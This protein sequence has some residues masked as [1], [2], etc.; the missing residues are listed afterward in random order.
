MSDARTLL[1]LQNLDID[2]DSCDA[3]LVDIAASLGESPDLIAAREA[4]TAARKALDDLR[5]T[6]KDLEFEA[7]SLS[8]RITAEDKQ[9]YDGRGRGSRELEGLRKSVE[10]LKAHRR[11]I[12]DQILDVMGSIEAA[13]SAA[14]AG[15][16]EFARV[17]AE[18]KASQ[19]DMLER[20]DNLRSQL[21]QVKAQRERLANSIERGLL[22]RY[23]ELRRQRRGRAVALIER[24]TCQGCRISLPLNVVQHARA[25]RDLVPCPS[26]ERFLVAER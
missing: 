24:N 25:N 11:A 16:S 8:S 19:G 26:C 6:Q 12:E 13:E 9:M 20:Q 17:E 23:D 14:T 10:S 7:E 18:W 2:I 4:R 21:T 1:Q 22:A 3:A 15:D 5:S